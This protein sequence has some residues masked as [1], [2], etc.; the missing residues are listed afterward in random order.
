MHNSEVSGFTLVTLKNDKIGDKVSFL[1]NEL[2]EE[3]IN[4]LKKRFAE[5]PREDQINWSFQTAS[6][7]F[8]TRVPFF[9]K[10]VCY[11]IKYWDF[12]YSIKVNMEEYFERSKLAKIKKQNSQHLSEAE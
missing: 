10:A 7:R 5:I 8:F 11:H 12:R 4:D 6:N 9:M 1:I 2:S 3:G